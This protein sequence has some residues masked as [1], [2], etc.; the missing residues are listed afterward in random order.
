M[1][2]AHAYLVF[3]R[4]DDSTTQAHS[5]GF[6]PAPATSTDSL[7]ESTR[8]YS[9]RFTPPPAP[10]AARMA[11]H[12]PEPDSILGSTPAGNGPAGFPEVRALHFPE[13]PLVFGDSTNPTDDGDDEFLPTPSIQHPSISFDSSTEEPPAKRRLLF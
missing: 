11:R 2:L 10:S 9:F 6:L 12:R 8:V 5:T 13:I 7:S 3:Y 1:Q 4:F